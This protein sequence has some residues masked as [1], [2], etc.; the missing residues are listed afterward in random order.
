MVSKQE[1]KK[2]V[3]M[4]FLIISLAEEMS[5]ISHTEKERYLQELDL[6][7]I[8][9]TTEAIYGFE[10]RYEKAEPFIRLF[11][12]IWKSYERWLLDDDIHSFS[13]RYA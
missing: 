3:K 8:D 1:L 2:N 10:S 7:A 13:K 6:L 5:E 12:D 11:P 9:C 4:R